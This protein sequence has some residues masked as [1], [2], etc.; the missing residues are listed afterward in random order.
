M[1]SIIDDWKVLRQHATNLPL[2]VIAYKLDSYGE[3]SRLRVRIGTFGID[4]IYDAKD[5]EFDQIL[6][7]LDER[8]AIVIKEQRMDETFFM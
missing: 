5:D 1:V 7:F 8:N 6:R 4:R 3:K 2:A